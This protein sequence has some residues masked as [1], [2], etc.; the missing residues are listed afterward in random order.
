[1]AQRALLG[2]LGCSFPLTLPNLFS[3][4]APDEK[5][6]IEWCQQ[7]MLLPKQR[8][9]RC[10]R[11][12]S[13]RRRSGRDSYNWHCTDHSCVASVS[14]RKGTWFEGA[15][16]N[17]GTAL[18]LMYFW[19]FKFAV[20]DTA[21]HLSISPTTVVD[22]FNFLRELCCVFISEHASEQIGGPG[23]IVEIDESKFGKSKYN[24]GRHRPGQWVFGG[25][26]RAS[27]ACFLVSVDRRD[28]ATLIPIIYRY[29]RPGSTIISD[30][31]KAYTCL[32]D[33]PQF[34]HLTVNHSINFVDPVTFAHTNT[35]EGMW[36]HAKRRVGSTTS[37]LFN[38][39]LFEFMWRKRFGDKADAWMSLVQHIS[40]IY[41]VNQE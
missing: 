27:S 22:W 25:I 3:Q 23:C 13:L 21:F 33:S 10:G 38:S 12:M 14:L 1:M 36:M 4:V 28:S 15:H 26:D 24:R 34:Q 20:V 11:Q 9:C 19:C 7:N 6:A 16:I 39:Y 2:S 29:V 17:V 40:V 37:A 30:E 35:I 8:K 31:W 18:K 32:R 5:K 41:P